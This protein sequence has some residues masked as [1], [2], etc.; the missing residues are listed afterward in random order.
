MAKKAEAKKKL[1]G[2]KMNK[3][4]CGGRS[5]GQ[6]RA[7][8]TG[9]EFMGL[10]SEFLLYVRST[11]YEI[12]PTRSMFLWWLKEYKKK[13]IDFRTVYLT[14]NEYYPEIKRFYDEMVAEALVEGSAKDQYK[15]NIVI[16][17]LKN[18][19]GWSDKQE[20]GNKDGQAFRIELDGKLSDW[21]KQLQ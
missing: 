21:S 19:C 20:I 12:M 16:F 2:Q 3:I 6:P 10:F 15:Q 1:S 5:A 13:K 7:F 9:D 4:V 17:A 18:W 14:I 8:A 11:N